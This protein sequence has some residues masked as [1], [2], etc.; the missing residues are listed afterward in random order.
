MTIHG[1]EVLASF[2]VRK[3][4]AQ[5]QA[6]A[7]YVA[8]K[9]ACYGYSFHTEKGSFGSEN[10]VVGDVYRA[11]VL[12]TAHYDTCPR[13][14]FPNFITPKN[15]G[16]YV[17]YQVI[18][19]AV[20]LAVMFGGEFL[21]GLGLGYLGTMLPSAYEGY[22]V[23]ASGVLGFAWYLFMFF[24]LLS[25]PANKHTANDNT[26]GVVTLLDTMA[27]M[28]EELKAEVAFVFFDL[29]EMG[30]IGSSAFG[31]RHKEMLKTKLLINYD[32]VSDGDTMLFCVKKTA[33]GAI[34]LME[35]AFVSNDL[36]TVEFAA[37]GFIYPSDQMMA[38]IGVGVAALKK[39]RN[40][41]LLY[42]DRIHTAKDTV[43]REE[44]IFFLTNGSIAL[45]NLLKEQ[46]P[47]D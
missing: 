10:L 44:N 40:G 2:Q 37:K 4:K 34:P 1:N 5:K 33:W 11:K 13:L 20:L 15:I 35:R 14:P 31:K 16:I 12:Y 36:V 6:F 18:L 7:A 27:M 22:V 43:F 9:A 39:S 26:S 8:D 28:P 17:L 21:I 3:K 38:P 47:S 23:I 41:K 30:M 45:A 19:T 25:G 32:C 46:A 24:F 42:M 29:E